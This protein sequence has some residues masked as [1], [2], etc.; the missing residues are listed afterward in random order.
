MINVWLKLNLMGKIFK[1]IYN[2]LFHGHGLFSLWKVYRWERRG[3]A[4]RK[5]TREIEETKV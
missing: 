4:C 3:V 2:W 1:W 5:C